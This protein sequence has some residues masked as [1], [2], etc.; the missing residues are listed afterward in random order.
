MATTHTVYWKKDDEADDDELVVWVEV[1]KLD[2]CWRSHAPREYLAQ[3]NGHRE[4]FQ[5]LGAAIRDRAVLRMPRLR[6]TDAQRPFQRIDF[7][8]G[9]HRFAFVR[10]HGG[11]FMPVTIAR[12]EVPRAKTL[13]GATAWRCEVK[14]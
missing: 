3:G 1:V 6:F 12:A 4:T 14:V 7:L 10:D 13:F 8:D 11:A 2:E 9:R 5:Y